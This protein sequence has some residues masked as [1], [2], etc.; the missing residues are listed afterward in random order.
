MVAT[1]GLALVQVPPVTV[2][3]NVVGVPKHA[4]DV[5]LKTPALGAALM[6]TV[7]VSVTA[8]QPAPETV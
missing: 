4:I 3:L 7:L 1:D 2:E 5:P 6:L 8:V